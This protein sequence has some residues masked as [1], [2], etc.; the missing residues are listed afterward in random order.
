MLNIEQAL[1]YAKDNGRKI[2][3]KELGALLWPGRP[4]ITQQVNMTNLCSGKTARI[5]P[6]WVKIICAATGVSANFLLG[7]NE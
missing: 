2:T 6:D 3:K 5:E 1:A 4:A 7:I